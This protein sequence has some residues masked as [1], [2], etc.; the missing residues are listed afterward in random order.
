MNEYFHNSCKEYLKHGLP[1]LILHGPHGSGKTYMVNAFVD[2]YLEEFRDRV[3]DMSI[4]HEIMVK[5]VECTINKATDFTTRVIVNFIKKKINV[6]K[7]K[8]IIIRDID[9]LKHEY[10]KIIKDTLETHVDRCSFIFITNNFEDIIEDIQRL[11]IIFKF[12]K[13]SKDVIR[14]VL[15]SISPNSVGGIILDDELVHKIS[16]NADGDIRSAINIFNIYKYAN[17]KDK[18]DSLF[19]LPTNKNMIKLIK[20]MIKKDLQKSL[21]LMNSFMEDG[22]CITDIVDSLIRYIKCS[23]DI[24]NDDKCHLLEKITFSAYEKYVPS[25]NM[26]PYYLLANVIGK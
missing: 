21:N 22:F 23:S 4:V 25:N 7:K 16:L 1:S 10:Q 9:L 18:F 14:E 20:S 15:N 19:G 26:M 13:A 12:N 3:D 24:S 5:N 8:I 6:T 17:D 11:C 2:D